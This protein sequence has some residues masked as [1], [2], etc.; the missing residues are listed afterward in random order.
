M[1]HCNLRIYEKSSIYA[2]KA[3][4]LEKL[5]RPKILSKINVNNYYH[6]KRL[7]FFPDTTC[8]S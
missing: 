1:P 4:D 8:I 5:N 6:T 2:Y 7:I 3:V